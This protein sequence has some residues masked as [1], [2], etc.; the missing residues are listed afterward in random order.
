MRD[1][2][3]TERQVSF[4]TWHVEVIRALIV[5]VLMVMVDVLVVVLVMYR[6]CSGC[7]MYVN[8]VFIHNPKR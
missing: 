8:S 2:F 6:Y 4:H 5:V 1:K 7:F 3:G